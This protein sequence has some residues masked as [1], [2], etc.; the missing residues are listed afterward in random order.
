MLHD[1]EGTTR[2]PEAPRASR[3]GPTDT[4]AYGAVG[5]KADTWYHPSQKPP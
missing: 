5:L 1:S 4:G 3:H 2:W